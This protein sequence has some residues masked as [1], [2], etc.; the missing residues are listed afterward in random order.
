MHAD[1]NNEIVGRKDKEPLYILEE[2][3]FLEYGLASRKE[4]VESKVGGL[5]GNVYLSQSIVQ[6]NA[7]MWLYYKSLNQCRIM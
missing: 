5:V 4:C 6:E 1:S 3:N 7:Y 2:F